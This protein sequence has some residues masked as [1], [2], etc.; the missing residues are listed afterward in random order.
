MSK[1]ITGTF[2]GQV[3]KPDSLTDVGDLEPQARYRITLE[4]LPERDLPVLNGIDG[5][6]SKGS[7][8]IPNPSR[9]PLADVLASIH[10]DLRASGYRPR[11]KE[12]VDAYIEEERN[13]WDDEE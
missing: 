9:R 10:S 6:S 7:S 11:T 3:L 4:R 2:D 1:V 13:S 8:V 12:E 5:D